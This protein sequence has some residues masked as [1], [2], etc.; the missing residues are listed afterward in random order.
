[1]TLFLLVL[2]LS[3][4]LYS[5]QSVPTWSSKTLF[6]LSVFFQKIAHDSSVVYELDKEND[7]VMV[8]T[9]KVGEGEEEVMAIRRFRRQNQEEVARR[10]SVI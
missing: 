1:M 2:T 7:D 6:F 5:N 4:L 8:V 9:S 3:N 10:I